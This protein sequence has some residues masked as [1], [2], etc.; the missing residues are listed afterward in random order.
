MNAEDSAEDGQAINRRIDVSHFMLHMTA[1]LVALIF[2]LQQAMDGYSVTESSQIFMLTGT[3]VLVALA[4]GYAFGF[5][6]GVT[7]DA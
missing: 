1:L 4:V 6:S 3:A 2:A 5:I 7:T